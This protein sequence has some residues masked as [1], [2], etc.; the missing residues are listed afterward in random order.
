MATLI[1]SHFFG[2]HAKKQLNHKQIIKLNMCFR[3]LT[4]L[5]KTLKIFKIH[6]NF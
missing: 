4:L 3:S 1:G 2:G 5:L 6:I